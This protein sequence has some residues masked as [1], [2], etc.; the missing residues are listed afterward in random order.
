[1]ATK[2]YIV[3]NPSKT[4][5]V[6]VNGN[7]ATH[8]KVVQLAIDPTLTDIATFLDNGCAIFEIPATAAPAGSSWTI[9]AEKCG[10]L[11]ENAVHNAV[12]GL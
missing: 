8:N 9:E 1:V 12:A 2:N 3:A 11:F 10:F 7:T 5:D 4:A 6:T